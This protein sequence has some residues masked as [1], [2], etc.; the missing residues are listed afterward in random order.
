MICENYRNIPIQFY[1]ISKFVA[2]KQDIG[3][4]YGATLINHISN[5][6]IMN[7]YL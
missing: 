7:I 6:P 2:H 3:T 5:L 1:Q 4:S